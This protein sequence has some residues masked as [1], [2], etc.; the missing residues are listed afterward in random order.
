MPTMDQIPQTNDPIHLLLVADS[1]VGKSVY[2]AQAAIDGFGVVYIDSDNGISAARWAIAKANKPEALKR[3]QY[4]QTQKPVDFVKGLLRSTSKSPFIWSPRIDRQWGKTTVDSK[5]DDKLW[6][7]DITKL[8]RQHILVQDSWTSIAGDAL[9]IGSSAQAAEI[10]DE[11]VN[12]QGIYGDANG[13]LTFIAN[14]LQKLPNHVIV[15]AHGT[16]FERYEKPLN[17]TVRDAKQN[18]F[19]LKETMEVPISSSRP[20]GKEMASRFN[21]IGWLYVN[22]LGK[23]EIDFTRKSDRV[24][25]GPPDTKTE[26]EKLPFSKLTGGVPEYVD[27]TG[28][29]IETTVAEVVATQ[30]AKPGLLPAAGIKIGG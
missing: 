20:H 3:I 5:S 7:F 21:H 2:A 28:F 23:T 4:F 25:G 15:L 16:V 11:D 13:N 29:C 22:N 27:P 6:V 14:M 30:P 26:V 10:L 24:G 1:K 17:V 12:K 19:K 8:P 9:G 18:M